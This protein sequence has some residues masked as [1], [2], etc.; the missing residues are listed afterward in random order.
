MLQCQEIQL[1]ARGSLG[2]H[3]HCPQSC[4]LCLVFFDGDMPIRVGDR[5]ARFYFLYGTAGVWYG[6]H[7][8][9]T[10]IVSSGQLEAIQAING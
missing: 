8:N 4:S 6:I 5:R 7:A 1:L 9:A 2:G 3:I 10:F